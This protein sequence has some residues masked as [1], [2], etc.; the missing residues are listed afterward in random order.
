VTIEQKTIELINAE[1]DGVNS[2]EESE[3]LRR[4]LEVDLE[5]GQLFEDLKKLGQGF[6]TLP[7][8]LPPL[9]LKHAVMRSIQDRQVQAGKM[10]RKPGLLDFLLPARPTLRPAFAFGGGVLAGALLI[11]LY[12]TIASY[13]S[14][15]TRDASGALLDSSSESLQTVEETTVAREGATARIV[16]QDA[17]NLSV[18][19]VSLALKPDVTARIVFDPDGVKIKG[20][21]LAD[22]FAGTVTQSRGMVEVGHGGGE[23]KAFFAPEASSGQNVRLQIVESGGVVYER[24]C[25]LEKVY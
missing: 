4:T 10:V 16:T 6:S 14:V 13:P 22:G 3:L 9:T 17:G 5:A 24:L 1:I 7:R 8:V 20:V 23:F 2:P 25:P 15:D 21:A 19:R 12:F 11:M 18:M